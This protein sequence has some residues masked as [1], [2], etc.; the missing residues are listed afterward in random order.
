M[1]DID[2]T[3]DEEKKNTPI[4]AQASK[5]VL[6]DL[7]EA[8]VQPSAPEIE[9]STG[10]LP[11]EVPVS[12]DPLGF[13]T[14]AAAQA[15]M[16]DRITGLGQSAA[17]VGSSL[18][19]GL[20]SGVAG[21]SSAVINGT[22][23]NATPADAL[24]KTFDEW[25]KA[26]TYDPTTASGKRY[27]QN[28]G[29]FLEKITKVPGEGLGDL[30]FLY[31]DALNSPAGLA[32]LIAGEEGQASLATALRMI[33]DTMLAFAGFRLGESGPR[34][35]SPKRSAVAGAP[36]YTEATPGVKTPAE[37][38]LSSGEPVPAAHLGAAEL[39]LSALTDL[40]GAEKPHFSNPADA[41]EY[42]NAVARGDISE[43]IVIET[44]GGA[45]T[46]VVGGARTIHALR[47]M[48]K[49]H[50]EKAFEESVSLAGEKGRPIPARPEGL[51]ALQNIRD[52]KVYTLE[53]SPRNINPAVREIIQNDAAKMEGAFAKSDADLTAL[54]QKIKSSLLNSSSEMWVDSGARIK[55]ELAKAGELGER[56]IM[57]QELSAGATPRAHYITKQAYKDIYDGLSQ[58]KNINVTFEGKPTALSERQLLDRFLIDRRRVAIAKVK[59][60][61]N[62]PKFTGGT[63]SKEAGAHLAVMREQLSADLVAELEIRAN[64]YFDVLH[65]QLKDLYD[66]GLITS[67]EFNRL[68]KIDY[69]KTRFVDKI[70]PDITYKIG[71][72]APITVSESGITPF[73]KGAKSGAITDTELLLNEVVIRTQ[74]RIARNKA[75]QAL[76]DL[77]AKNPKNDIV[78]EASRTGEGKYK[79]PP[80]NT[81]ELKVR[82]RGEEK[83][84]WM[85]EHLADAWITGDPQMS[86]FLADM[87]RVASGTSIVKALAT[88]YNPE[89]IV[90]GLPRDLAH[91]WLGAG[92]GDVYSPFLPSYVLQGITDAATVAKDTWTRSGRYADFINE[93]GGM[94]FLTHQGRNLLSRVGPKFK[95]GSGWEKAKNVLSYINETFELWPRLALRE[96]A[97]KNMK[98]FG[99]D[100]DPVKATYIARDYLDFARGGTVAKS[101]DN[102]IPY[103]N[104]SIQGVR[105]ILRQTKTPKQATLLAAKVAQLATLSG[106][107]TYLFWYQ[108]PKTMEA[109]SDRK[110]RT[111]YNVPLDIEVIDDEGNVRYAY[112]PI[113][114]EQSTLPITSLIDDI[115][116]TYV[117]G[118]QPTASRIEYLEGIVPNVVGAIPSLQAVLEY[119]SNYRR[120]LDDKAW[121]GKQGIEPFA[122]FYQEP[123]RPTDPIY[124]DLGELLN[125]SPVRLQASVEDALPDNPF[126][127]IG[128][129]GYKAISEQQQIQQNIPLT[130]Y[131]LIS[132]I[133]LIRKVIRFTHP[134][135]VYMEKLHE[136]AR[137]ELTEKE[138]A[139]RDFDKLYAE[140]TAVTGEREPAINMIQQVG[141]V[142]PMLASVLAGQLEA[143]I[144]NQIVLDK[145]R[146]DADLPPAVWWRTAVGLDPNARAAVFYDVWRDTDPSKRSKLEQTAKELT[147]I[148]E[149]FWSPGFQYKFERSKQQFGSDPPLY[150]WER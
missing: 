7:T 47:S 139:V 124:R 134:A 105:T 8:E 61:K 91:I 19:G 49:Y 130:G 80:P 77:A 143:N 68:K 14:D 88:G 127:S 70:D 142:D 21:L 147:A 15:D 106:A 24:V 37:V 117:T 20:A 150:P 6:I 64:K 42:V 60:T 94:S 50:M 44:V 51:D 113:K 58:D 52:V 136:G 40:P 10:R 33:P 128:V 26:L 41:V 76:Y 122:E 123:G 135:E 112:L 103:F 72:K 109:L 45:P 29:H 145:L 22:I 31:S 87:L 63:G 129:L 101:L 86:S 102:M 82:I 111:A 36:A 89:F 84:L 56:A 2:L 141:Q 30:A 96:R 32:R 53:K 48:D 90:T 5:P 73:K 138:L 131:D 78:R 3:E 116:Y 69:L 16:L 132:E 104:A 97:I 120:F 34:T 27:V 85:D 18:I 83:T 125:L 95:H 93:G 55:A 62:E 100:V 108:S 126:V 133:P 12:E 148:G 114:K 119:H 98:E 65:Q 118:E 149:G 121:R 13:F 79:K 1:A 54:E 81:T 99:A 9:I 23:G 110:R 144:K 43:P 4:K 38:V 39:R 67:V 17:S 140:T 71:G 11:I 146:G 92:K 35:V 137:E 28:V 66:N 59:G 75:N 115:M 25:N 57:M 107:L 74:N 46:K